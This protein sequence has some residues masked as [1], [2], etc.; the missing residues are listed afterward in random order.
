[1]NDINYWK[2]AFVK[3][4]V[5]LNILGFPGDASG[6]KPACQFRRHKICGFSA[7]VRKILWRRLWKPTPVFLPGKRHEQRSLV[8]YSS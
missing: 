6:K 8:S 1:M 3:F 4:T 7:W 2:W 5:P